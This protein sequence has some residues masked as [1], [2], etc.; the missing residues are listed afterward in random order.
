MALGRIRISELDPAR[1]NTLSYYA[2][3]TDS[4]PLLMTK[5]FVRSEHLAI[6]H[7]LDFLVSDSYLVRDAASDFNTNSSGRQKSHYLVMKQPSR[8]YF[9]D[10]PWKTYPSIST[11]FIR[12][13][14]PS[15]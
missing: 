15:T 3:L 11:C 10:A 1:V 9:S 7:I 8:I 12:T 13:P 5:I 4:K 14:T 2:C 6:L